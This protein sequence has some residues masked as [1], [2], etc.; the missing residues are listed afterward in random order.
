LND[1][2]ANGDGEG[3]DDEGSFNSPPSLL[4]ENF[5]SEIMTPPNLSFN[6]VDTPDVKEAEL[7]QIVDAMVS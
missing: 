6:A 5:K 3:D 2:F 4:D 7:N 1:S